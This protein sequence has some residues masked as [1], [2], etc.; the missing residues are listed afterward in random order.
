MRQFC[1]IEY[2]KIQLHRNLCTFCTIMAKEVSIDNYVLVAFLCHL[3]EKFHGLWWT[4]DEYCD[5]LRRRG[6][7][8]DDVNVAVVWTAIQRDQSYTFLRNRFF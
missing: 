6:G 2:H 8:K 4:A 7:V 3:P 5:M 1:R